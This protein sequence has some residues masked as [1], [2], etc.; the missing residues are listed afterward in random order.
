MPSGRMNTRMNSKL[1]A[2]EP[3]S[4]IESTAESTTATP[5]KTTTWS[6]AASEIKFT[7]PAHPKRRL[8]RRIDPGLVTGPGAGVLLDH[9]DGNALEALRL[10]IRDHFKA[11]STIDLVLAELATASAWRALRAV[12]LEGS[13]IDTQ[14]DE[15][16]EAVNRVYDDIDGTCRAALVFQDAAV[17][18]ILRQFSQTANEC[19]R[20]LV[21]LLRLRSGRASG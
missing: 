17:A 1:T 15:Q 20:N 10:S 19:Q 7:P 21:S 11:K 13:T 5:A 4:P 12:D 9:E 6:P 2:P 3:E 18:R 8:R 14:V 16:S